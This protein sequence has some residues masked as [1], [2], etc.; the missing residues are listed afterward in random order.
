MLKD[1]EIVSKPDGEHTAL[2]LEFTLPQSTYATMLL[3]EIMV[4]WIFF[5]FNLLISIVLFAEN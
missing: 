1:P 3:R 4:S 2:I 5:F